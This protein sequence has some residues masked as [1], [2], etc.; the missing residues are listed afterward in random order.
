MTPGYVGHSWALPREAV[1]AALGLAPDSPAKRRTLEDL[2]AE[3]GV[4]VADLI[5]ALE[6]AIAAHRAGRP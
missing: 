6:A 2:A 1:G 3:R 4:P 5:A